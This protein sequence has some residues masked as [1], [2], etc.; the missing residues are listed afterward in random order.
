MK[1]LNLKEVTEGLWISNQGSAPGPKSPRCMTVVR[2]TNGYLWV[3]APIPFDESVRYDLSALGEIRCFVLPAFPA[4]DRVEAYSHWYPDARFFGVR[5][6]EGFKEGP[7]IKLLTDEEGDRPAWSQEID[8]HAIKGLSRLQETV[9]FHRTT[10]T[11]MVSEFIHQ[12][13]QPQGWLAS[14]QSKIGGFTSGIGFS[15]IFKKSIRNRNELK[16]SLET[17]RSWPIKRVISGCGS[18]LESNE[19]IASVSALLEGGK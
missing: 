11:L 3:H 2:L 13:K 17:I 16:A 12:H 8:Y 18:V 7:S 14:V 19:D 9:F 6:I 1:L 5:S 10:G 4:R 15:R